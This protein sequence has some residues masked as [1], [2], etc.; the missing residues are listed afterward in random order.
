MGIGFSPNTIPF[1]QHFQK[2]KFY[3]CRTDWRL[4]GVRGGQG[5]GG[6]QGDEYGYTWTT[7]GIPAVMFCILTMVVNTQIHTGDNT[8]K[9]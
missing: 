3:R 7:G 9:H 5:R 4:P 2:K 8:I 1:T 6:A